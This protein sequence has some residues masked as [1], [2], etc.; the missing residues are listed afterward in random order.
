MLDLAEMRVLCD[1]RGS[2]S[3]LAESQSLSVVGV[4]PGP[5]SV[6]CSVV[7]LFVYQSGGGFFL[8]LV[9]IFCSGWEKRSFFRIGGQE[10]SHGTLVVAPLSNFQQLQ[11]T[12]N[13][14]QHMPSLV[15]PGTC[16]ARLPRHMLNPVALANANSGCPQQML[17]L[18]APGTCQARLPP[19]M[20]NPVALANAK[21]GSPGKTLN[22]VAWQMLNLVVATVF[23]TSQHSCNTCQTMH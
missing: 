2:L 20:L 6:P 23:S 18:V 11:K 1:F 4:F 15:A 9:W 3:R 17:N 19:H 7:D 22:T 5:A 13:N 21:Y 12:G 8:E 10:E 16:Q 14:L